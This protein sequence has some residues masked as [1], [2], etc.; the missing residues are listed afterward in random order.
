[1]GGVN[2]RDHIIEA[3]QELIWAKGYES[4]SIKDITTAAGLPKGSFYHYFESKEKFVVEAMKDYLAKF[5][6]LV[7]DPR[8]NLKTLEE[9]IDRRI[10]SILKINFERECYMSV[11]AHAYSDQDEEFRMEVIHGI[12][13]ANRAMHDLLQSLLNDGLIDASF[14]LEE[15]MEFVD[16]AWRGARLKARLL[17]SDAPLRI[18]K[19]YLM[20]LVTSA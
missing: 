1:M 3:G 12:E 14:E 4:C 20:L 13:D 11:M 16:F 18:F 19:K 10:E 6:E 2:K 7:S 15:L 17:K 9:V 5:P 8:P